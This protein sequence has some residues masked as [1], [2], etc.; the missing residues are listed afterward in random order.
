MKKVIAHV[1]KLFVVALGFIVSALAAANFV[2]GTILSGWDNLHPEFNISVNL[3]RSLS[4]TWQEYQG[5]GLLGGMGHGA[6]LIRQL[7]FLVLLPFIGKFDIRYTWTFAMIFVGSFG[8]YSLTK[9]LVA[10]RLGSIP[11]FV[12][13]LFY[14]FNLATLQTFY[15]P[16]ETFTN[17]FGFF[18]WLVWGVLHYLKSPRRKNLAILAFVSLIS[19]PSFYV[20]TLFIVWMIVLGI[21]LLE[22]VIKNRLLGLKRAFVVLLTVFV[23]NAFWLLPSLY[24]TFTKSE[25]VSEAKGNILSTYE[26]Y[27]MNKGFAQVENVALLKGYWFEYTDAAANGEDFG[28]LYQDWRSYT[29]SGGFQLA[30]YALF[31]IS[32]AGVVLQL[33][34]RSEPHRASLVACFGLSL[35]LLIVGVD[36]NIPLLG[37]VFRSVFT[38]WSIVA[39]LFFS[40]GIGFFVASFLHIKQKILQPVLVT[41]MGILCLCAM[42]PVGKQFF[43]GKLISE[44][45]RVETPQAYF[46]LFDYFK[47]QPK[48]NR[49][50]FFPVQSFWGWN[51]TNWGYRGSGFLWYG[52]EQPIL[53]RAFD[54][55]SREN[56][57]F[58]NELSTAFYAEDY[59]MVT[60]II[61]KY[62]VSYALVDKSV[63]I[64][65]GSNEPF[66]FDEFD[67]FMMG[68][69]APIVWQKDFLAVYDLKSLHERPDSFVYAPNSFVESAADTSYSRVDQTYSLAGDYIDSKESSYPFATASREEVPVTYEGSSIHFTA[70][71]SVQEKSELVIPPLDST[72]TISVSATVTYVGN[73]ATIDFDSL[74][75]VK[76]NDTVLAAIDLPNLYF[77]T[78]KVYAK[79]AVSIGGAIIHVDQNTSVRASTIHLSLDKPLDVDVFDGSQ[80]TISL[81]NFLDQEFGTCWMKPGESPFI[82]K[83]QTSN[84]VMLTVRNS[85]ACTSARIGTPGGEKSL[86]GASVMYRSQGG[87]RP[88]FCIQIEGSSK[89][90]TDDIF[91]HS[92]PSSEWTPV[93]RELVVDGSKAYWFVLSARASDDISKTWSIEYQDPVITTYDHIASFQ[94]FPNQWSEIVEEKRVEVGA[95]STLSVAFMANPKAISLGAG[96]RVEAYNCDI[97]K[98]GV[99][100][101]QVN[102]GGSPTYEASAYASSCDF[103]VIDKVATNQEHLLRFVG[104]NESGRSL[105]FYLFNK[106]TNRND[107]EMLLSRGSFD[108]S[109]A[110]LPWTQFD[111]NEY[112]LNVETRSFGVEVSKNTLTTVE[113]YPAPLN[114]LSH[115]RLQSQPTTKFANNV[116]VDE[117]QKVGTY[118]YSGNVVS[119]GDGVLALSQGFDDGWQAYS[120]L[121]LLGKKL[122]H[123]RFNGWANAW[124]VP[125]GEQNITIIYL[126]QL[127]QFFGFGLLVGIMPLFILRYI[128]RKVDLSHNL[129]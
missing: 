97:F 77:S 66:R 1:D 42:L 41:L 29:T 110:L 12:A 102:A 107:L 69:Q 109:F 73:L 85:V 57:T 18:P 94:F 49:I 124:R 32:V 128:R 53:D 98:R 112:V 87:S 47:L 61:D 105:K 64:P 123:H 26:T 117:F 100:Q 21:F 25:V 86:L 35:F 45:M 88:Y 27:L 2:S 76:T 125:T 82:E 15:T 99:A 22:E 127:L 121:P 72:D 96:G 101:K 103:T 59:E 80:N 70:A 114:W 55:W 7:I 68:I 10:K 6:D 122:P 13:S 37:Q 43:E 75:Q 30:G 31:I 126:P 120:G 34:R 40:L 119:E 52:I 60:K 3:F 17:F 48:Q 14:I 65:G 113:A 104:E 81:D 5:L 11:A 118:W 71:N 20:Q 95:G 92:V 9:L 54:V 83:Q 106:A 116:Q 44:R 78:D 91:Y 67:A 56:E 38:K 115:W 108:Q 50:A 79:V 84:G 36:P 111:P 23:T 129:Q 74:Y 58:Y 24:F 89:C 63:I 4:V 28:Y 19:T 51:F 39:S 33:F 8:V 93:K 90:E 46:E 16:F 62:D